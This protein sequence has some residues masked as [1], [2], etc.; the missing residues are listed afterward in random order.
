MNLREKEILI[1]KDVAYP[2]VDEYD[3][4]G[5]DAETKHLLATAVNEILARAF[6]IASA[7]NLPV[8]K[9]VRLVYVP[10]KELQCRYYECG[11][12]SSRFYR[13]IARFWGLNYGPEL[14]LLMRFP[15][16]VMIRTEG[17]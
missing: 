6:V 2:S 13:T 7:R 17:E 15:P 1:A 8:E 3:F 16:N 12:C 5:S 11:L 10:M 9:I 4:D 14:Y